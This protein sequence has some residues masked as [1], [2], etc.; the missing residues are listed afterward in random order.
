MSGREYQYSINKYSK[1]NKI[2]LSKGGPYKFYKLPE[3]ID[4]VSEAIGINLQQE[5]GEKARKD[6]EKP[7][8]MTQKEQPEQD[9]NAG[10]KA[11]KDFERPSSLK[12]NKKKTV[13][14]TMEKTVEYFHLH[15]YVTV[16]IWNKYRKSRSE[17]IPSNPN[18]IYKGI[19][20]GF[21]AIREAFLKKYEDPSV[22][23]PSTVVPEAVKIIEEFRNAKPKS[24]LGQD[25]NGYPDYQ[26]FLHTF[27][28]YKILT[29]K[30]YFDFRK[31][32]PMKLPMN[33]VGYY[34]K[35][36]SDIFNDIDKIKTT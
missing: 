36:W 4:L 28:S 31:R 18:I 34:K 14:T 16:T 15:G 29:S 3:D 2:G 27:K 23:I 26:S 32:S 9:P 12:D 11:Q 25:E 21:P 13:F 33:P 7:K 24:E 30:M 6:F 17:E 1:D 5:P 10:Q 8:S 19:W 22:D 20:I 35:E